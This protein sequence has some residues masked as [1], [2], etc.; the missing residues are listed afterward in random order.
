[1]ATTWE[2]ASSRIGSV[3][4]ETKAIAK[5]I[6]TAAQKAGHDIWFM[7]GKSGGTGEHSTGLAIDYMVR[8]HAGGQFVRDYIWTN[9]ARLR[10]KHVIWEQHITSTVYR[11]GVVVKMEDRGNSTA[12]HMDHVH[13][14]NFAGAYRPPVVAPPK[15]P[16][17]TVSQIADEVIA[18][19]WGNGDERKRKLTAAGY[20]PAVIQAEVN[21][22]LGLKPAPVPK[23][24]LYWN[25]SKA[26]SGNDVLAL[27]KG[28]RRVF[29][30]YAGSL[31][32][33]GV[34]GAATDKAVREFQR[35][36]F[37]SSTGQVGPITRA[38]LARYGV[39]L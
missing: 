17:K 18:G 23:R 35:R 28:L 6:F 11:P 31:K 29:P 12:N 20:N 25:K 15:P 8:N 27:Q 5:E 37:I 26:L 22:K 4:P 13:A 7:W 9:R 34:F 21:R 32:L 19:K 3:E 10:L 14:L 39:Q 38:T 2:Y 24:T 16:V 1:M 36:A 33:D 30:L